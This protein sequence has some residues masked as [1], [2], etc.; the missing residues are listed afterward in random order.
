MPVI[1]FAQDGFIERSEIEKKEKLKNDKQFHFKDL[2]DIE[3]TPVKNQ[4]SSGTCWS[5]AANS[6]MESEM[7]RKGKLPYELSEMYMLR[8]VLSDKADAYVRMHGNIAWNDGGECHDV[9]NMFSDYGALPQTIYPGLENGGN[10]RKLSEMMSILKGILDAVINNPDGIHSADWK[11][12]FDATLDLYLGKVPVKF[13]FDGFSYTPLSFGQ[14]CVG[15]H[16]EDY[17]EISSF[18]KDPLYKKIKLLLPDNWSF[19]RVYNVK[20]E[21]LTS[22]ID[23]A[24]TKGY[25]VAWSADVSESY[26]GW[27]KGIAYVPEKEVDDMTE[28]EKKEMFEGPKPEKYVS[29]SLRQKAFDNYETT[30]DHSMH[31]VGLAEDKNHKKYYKVKNSWDTQNGYY[32]YIYV[33]KTY[34]QYKTTSILLHKSAL[35]TEVRNQLNLGTSREY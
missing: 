31:I 34:V 30:D 7:M 18:M 26:F 6:F 20:M 27:D 12:A 24:L 25:S 33:T 32:G 17:I 4:L 14:K 29:P 21:D 22:I 13:S 2:I 16:P 23:Y 35:T 10:H 5:Y 1:S 8:M 9:L 11:K 19:N 3:H 28:T 15:I